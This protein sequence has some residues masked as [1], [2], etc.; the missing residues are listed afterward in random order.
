MEEAGGLIELISPAGVPAVL[1]CA[2]F[3]VFEFLEHVS[4]K[5]VKDTL[6]DQIKHFDA[7]RATT[8]PQSA[9]TLFNLMFGDK[10]FSLHC[11]FRSM[12]MSLFGIA[13]FT[14]VA[15]IIYF[16]RQPPGPFFEDV[17]ALTT[18]FTSSQ[19]VNGEIYMKMMIF[20]LPLSVTL[21]YFM[22]LKTRLILL[23]VVKYRPKIISIVLICSVDFAFSYVFFYSILET[24]QDSI[25]FGEWSIPSPEDIWDNVSFLVTYALQ[26]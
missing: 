9:K 22:L 10:H 14:T 7:T 3:G 2:T 6:T 5:E 1:A 26:I 21:D 4:S 23:G 17:T 18:R 8:L 24:V 20:W 12:C 16:T 11:L 15:W 19:R 13:F 25:H